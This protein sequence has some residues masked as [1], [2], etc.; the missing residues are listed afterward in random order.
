MTDGRWV[1]MSDLPDY[2]E[3]YGVA[4]PAAFL[5]EIRANNYVV[6]ST[7][8]VSIEDLPSPPVD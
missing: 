7:P 2:V 4:L 5:R 1:W 6:P 3:Q 8:T